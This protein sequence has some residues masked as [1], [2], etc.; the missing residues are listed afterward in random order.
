MKF[1]EGS[2]TLNASFKL[3]VLMKMFVAGFPGYFRKEELTELFARY[4]KVLSA[5]VIMDPKTGGSKYF[6]FVE[7]S[8]IDDAKKA[9]E[10]LN[11][12]MLEDRRLV[13]MEANNQK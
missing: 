5:R 13:V 1:I 10:V 11:E 3:E 2:G 6:G 4:G 12:S 9:T 8:N 7:I